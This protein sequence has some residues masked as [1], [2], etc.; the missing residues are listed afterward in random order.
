M[1]IPLGQVVTFDVITSNPST[2]AVSDADSTP[3]FAVYEET[4]DT[5]I[6]VGGN[7]TKRTSLTGNYRGQFTA[8]GANGFEAGKFYN[9][10]ASATVNSVAG[11]ARALWFRCTLA[12]N[13]AGVLPV[14]TV[15]VNNT[16]QTARDL[17]AQLDAQVSTRSSHAAA[18]VWSVGTRAL[19]DKAGFSL[20]SAGVQA[21]W[22]ALTSALT[23]AGS[24][25]KW[26]VDKLDAVVS[27][28][29]SHSAADVWAAGTRTLT[30]SV[31]VGTNNDKTGYSLTSAYDPAKTAAQA[32]DAMTLT[33][34]YDAAKTAGDATA[35][36][37]TTINNN[38]LALPSASAI[39]TAVWAAGTRTLSSF[40]TLVSDIATAVW[41]AGTRTLTAFGFSVT[42]S[43][44]TDKTGY[45]LTSDYDP[46]KT[47]APTAAE[48]AD[49]LLGR[50][51]A[52]G[53]DGGR[54]VT[55]ALR[56]GRNKVDLVSVP[57]W[58]LVF[59]E[60]DTTESWRAQLTTNP[61]AEPI[62]SVDPQ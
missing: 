11:K 1:N 60:D 42:A 61:N 58:M 41:S 46:A 7:L 57:G 62:T 56:P 20:S 43:S 50:N 4:T 54:T 36:N 14:D 17:G 16:T 28:R 2:G 51:I 15:R 39:A 35:A 22:D 3:T 37:Q 19:T 6:G 25:G 13:T 31:T 59:E 53:S 10:I 45:A 12:E 27:T 48:N 24:I 30:G 21:I 26:I 8:S 40:G 38:I 9:V 29:S 44:V 52:G 18:D 33:A 32:G 34:A 23:T 47:A 55:Q 5:D 49:K